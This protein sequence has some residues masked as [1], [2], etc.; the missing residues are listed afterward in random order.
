MTSVQQYLDNAG[1][2]PA[3]LRW[4]ATHEALVRHWTF[5]LL[6]G[7]AD[8]LEAQIE[9]NSMADNLKGIPFS[10]DDEGKSYPDIAKEIV[11]EFT[12]G[13]PYVVIFAY[14]LGNWKALVST[15]KPDGHYYEVTFKGEYGV[16]FVDTYIK[17][18]NR[19]VPVPPAG[20]ASS[21]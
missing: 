16:A 1:I 3:G 11:S 14:V 15:D 2:T 19:E 5:D 8:V 18:D 6:T 20:Q 12:D 10:S 13:T 17:A 4:A 21:A 7:L 9:R